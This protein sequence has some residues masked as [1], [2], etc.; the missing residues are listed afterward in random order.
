[1]TEE[2]QA[3]L[4]QIQKA[5]PSEQSITTAIQKAK[6]SIFFE[7]LEVVRDAAHWRDV[8]DHADGSLLEGSPELE[9]TL[10]RW[11]AELGSRAKARKRLKT[12][13]AAT[14]SQRDAPVGIAV[15]KS[16]L[17][18]MLKA[19]ALSQ[20]GSRDLNVNFIKIEVHGDQYG[21]I[22]EIETTGEER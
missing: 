12:A 3:Q 13:Q 6:E 8:Y 5:K 2:E 21:V 10:L 11:E 7:A 19:D 14:R 18:G 9:E 20:I 1:V 15:A 17:V 16:I 4:V 22:D